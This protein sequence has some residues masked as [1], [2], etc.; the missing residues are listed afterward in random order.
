[1]NN[2]PSPLSDALLCLRKKANTKELVQA[3]EH[4]WATG[5]SIHSCVIEFRDAGLVD[6]FVHW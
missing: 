1:M 5:L 3:A 6:A 4:S 2:E